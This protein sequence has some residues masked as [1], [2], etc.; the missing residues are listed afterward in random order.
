MQLLTSDGLGLVQSETFNSSYLQLI[1]FSSSTI[2]ADIF[3]N[4]ITLRKNHPFSLIESL[5]NPSIGP[6][7]CKISSPASSYFYVLQYCMSIIIAN[8][9]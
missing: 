9:S 5:F 1:H 7:D 2:T 8:F 6:S 4:V 3:E